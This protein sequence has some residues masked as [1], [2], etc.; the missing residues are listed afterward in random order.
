MPPG[1]GYGPRMGRM[2]D[3][4]SIAAMRGPSFAGVPGG[5]GGSTGTL[6]GQ[7][8]RQSTGQGPVMPPAPGMGP[9]GFRGGYLLPGFAGGGVGSQ[10]APGS[11][12]IGG[13]GFGGIRDV[14]DRLRGRMGL[15][16]AG[17]GGNPMV[18]GGGAGP[19][20]APIPGGIPSMEGQ[21][22]L[23][24]WIRTLLSQQNQQGIFGPDYLTNSLRAGAMRN[25]DAQRSRTASLAGLSGLDPMSYRNAIINA[26]IMANRDQ[27]GA[28]N[29]AELAGITSHQDFIRNLLNAERSG[30][31]QGF[32]EH[33][34][35]RMAGDQGGGFG[36]FLGGVLG[37]G[38]GAFTGGL[39]G[40]LAG[41]IF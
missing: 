28:L 20:P 29:Q 8:G 32:L 6:G 13:Q 17:P 34:R 10:G 26:D 30:E 11:S 22:N 31:S 23:M 40:R 12:G 21:P 2:A 38:L 41:R 19:A 25:A 14:L 5:M 35:A 15:P 27:T 37:T 16:G 9:G 18:P 39:G 4:Q 3:E 24:N 33:E 7:G 1:I 36:G